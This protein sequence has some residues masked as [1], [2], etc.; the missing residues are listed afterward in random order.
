MI[1]KLLLFQLKRDVVDWNGGVEVRRVRYENTI[2]RKNG[3][4]NN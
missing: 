1:K 2:C 4:N 3:R